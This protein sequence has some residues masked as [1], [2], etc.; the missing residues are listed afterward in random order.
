M[1]SLLANQRHQISEHIGKQIESLRMFRALVFFTQLLALATGS[2]KVIDLTTKSFGELVIDESK[3]TA[4]V[5]FYAPWCPHCKKMTPDYDQLAKDFE[6]EED[7]LLIGNVDFIAE[8]WH[9]CTENI[10]LTSI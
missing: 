5:K 10:R 7:S 3:P 2:G 8:V 6:E 9:L 1:T 4:F